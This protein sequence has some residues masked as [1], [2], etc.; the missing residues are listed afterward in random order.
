MKRLNKIFRFYW[1]S[2]GLIIAILIFSCRKAPELPDNTNKV[3][4]P[5]VSMGLVSVI[6]YNSAECEGNVTNDGNSNVTARGFVWN[7]TGNPSLQNNAGSATSSGSTG[8]FTAT[9]S[10]LSEKTTYYVTAYATNVQGT[11][12]GA[13]T[14]FTTKELIAPVVTT[15]TVTNITS[16]AALA[17]GSV[18]SDGNGNVTARGLCWNT[19]GNPDLTNNIGYSNDGAGTGAFSRTL[20]NLTH[21]QQYFVRAYATNE[22]E[23]SYGEIRSFIAQ[24]PPCGELTIMVNHV[25]GNVSPVTKTV[26]Y[27]TVTNIPGET[28]KCWITRNLGADRQATSVSEAAEAPAGWYWQFNRKQG[29]KHDGSA[30]TPAWTITSIT[31]NSDWQAANDP[32]AIELGSGWRI[33][34]YTEWNNVDNAGNW[35]S[36]N[37]PWNSVLKLHAAGYLSLSDGSLYGRGSYGYYWSSTQYANSNGR[38][39]GFSSSDCSMYY[40]NKAYGSTLRCLR[41]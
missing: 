39:L 11:A 26:T 35:S 28:S 19:S 3:T 14:S 38:S 30:V 7:T 41:D 27:G 36:W 1:I 21:Q 32:C 17:G 24:D 25:A 23:T 29:Y 5:T 8:S 12:Y 13:E 15:S 31:E 37:G 4:I 18:T 33:P 40:G 16:S 10:N 9:L 34:T 20:T 22:K 6:K 2:Y